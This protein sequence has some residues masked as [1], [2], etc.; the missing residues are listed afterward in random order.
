MNIKEIE[1][2]VQ[3]GEILTKEELDLLWN[4]KLNKS[5]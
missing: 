2:K 1:F 3:S 4:Y 5:N